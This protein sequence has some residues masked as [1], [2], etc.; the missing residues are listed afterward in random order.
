MPRIRPSY[1]EA[2]DGLKDKVS[3]GALVDS[4]DVGRL[5]DKVGR[6]QHTHGRQ[7]PA[8][9]QEQLV[10]LPR[11]L[12]VEGAKVLQERDQQQPSL[13]LQ[14]LGPGLIVHQRGQQR[15]CDLL[16]W[17]VVVALARGILV[18]PVDAEDH[19]VTILYLK[20]VLAHGGLGA[21]GEDQL[22]VRAVLERAATGH[23]PVQARSSAAIIHANN[24]NTG[25]RSG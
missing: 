19:A 5:V 4:P 7:L 10:V 21:L 15:D 25:W 12:V 17:D 11:V 18:G 2:F 20:L 22:P 3:E 1:L 13:P 9:D 8:Q 14:T 24:Y 23:G 6:L 16:A